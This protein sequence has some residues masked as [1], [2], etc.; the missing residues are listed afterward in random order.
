MIAV[1][2]KPDQILVVE[3]FFEL[4]KTPWE[5]YRPGHAYDVVVATSD[6]VPAVDATLLIVYGSGP[7]ISDARHGMD[8]AARHQGL[9]VSYD[10]IPLPIY[11]ESV[12]F[13]E[14]GTG[15]PCL[16]ASAGVA[17]VRGNHGRVIGRGHREQ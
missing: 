14:N 7:R 9:V 2:S 11:G 4:F 12:T 17:G 1:L 16:Q 6:D 10:G 13:R 8:V 15:A 5:F 3:E